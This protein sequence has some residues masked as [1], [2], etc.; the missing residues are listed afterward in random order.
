MHLLVS[1][2]LSEAQAPPEL[3]GG[4]R[5][6]CDPQAGRLDRGEGPGE[7]EVKIELRVIYRPA[8]SYRDRVRR[9]YSRKVDGLTVRPA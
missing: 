1:R 6:W 8:G 4:R 7:A 5:A 9:A 2:G 3:S